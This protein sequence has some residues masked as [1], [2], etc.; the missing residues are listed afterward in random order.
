MQLSA[1]IRGPAQRRSIILAVLADSLDQATKLGSACSPAAPARARWSPY[2]TPTSSL[3]W[4]APRH[5]S[6]CWSWRPVSLASMTAVT[7]ASKES[8]VTQDG[9]PPTER[10]VAPRQTTMD[11]TRQAARAQERYYSTWGYS[12]SPALTPAK[13]SRPPDCLV[14]GLGGTPQNHPRPATPCGRARGRR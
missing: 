4:P 9:Q 1:S 8:A 7:Y 11:A 13:P 14:P 10:Q 2:V 5:R 12:N 3:A 6:S